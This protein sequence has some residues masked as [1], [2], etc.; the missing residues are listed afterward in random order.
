LPQA[1]FTLS[2]QSDELFREWQALEG[3]FQHQFRGFFAEYGLEL[4]GE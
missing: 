3:T 4:M 2:F 1:D